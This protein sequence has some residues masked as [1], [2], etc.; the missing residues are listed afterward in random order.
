MARE[1]NFECSL[2]FSSCHIFLSGIILHESRF[3][4]QDK[5]KA[6]S[7][8][9]LCLLGVTGGIVPCPAALV[10]LLSAFS[11]H[12]IGFG[13]FLIS[14]FS[15]GLA[16]VLVAVG[17]TMVYAKRAIASRVFAS[18]IG[19]Y[20]PILS[21][22]FM[23]LIG[24][25]IT[26]SA[27]S[28]VTLSRASILPGKLVPFVSIILLGLFLGMRHSTD[29]DHVVA[30]STIVSRQGSIRS[31]ATIGLLWGLGHTI[32]IFLV[33]SAIIVFGVV[34]PPRLGLSME[35]CVAL[36]LILLG[37]LNLTGA[38]QWFRKGMVS[39]CTRNRSPLEVTPASRR[40]LTCDA[41]RGVRSTWSA[42]VIKNTIGK[43][44]IYQTIRPLVVGLIHGLA[45]SAAVA[46]LVLSTIRSPLWSTAYLL[47]FGFGTMA[48]M[49]LMTAA[50]SVPF[51]YSERRFSS[52]SRHLTTIS[53]LA[54]LAF[55]IFLVYQIGFVDGLFL[56]HVHWIPQ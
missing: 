52:I 42:A 4:A 29:A 15:L 2:V 22:G 19:N 26:L 18:R 43:L 7:L 8:R 23:V 17:L 21:S 35:L 9:E 27:F 45:G 48:G 20:L 41:T 30:V 40:D 32:T 53:G 44:G 47:I 33:G 24:V 56:S 3:S 51:V 12:R 50:I 46:L 36:M 54:S 13:L 37:V 34:I 49:M 55:G 6:L 39:V 14:A 38:M 5:E 16:A 28:S 1:K 11:L 25:G 31:S 10:V